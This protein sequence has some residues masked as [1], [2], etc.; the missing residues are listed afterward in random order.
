M[1]KLASARICVRVRASELVFPCIELVS[2]RELRFCAWVD[3][4]FEEVN[5]IVRSTKGLAFTE[6]YRLFV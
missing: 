6:N 4:K 3:E 5:V 1:R 2:A